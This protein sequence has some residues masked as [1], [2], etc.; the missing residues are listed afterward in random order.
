LDAKVK[1]NTS[2]GLQ[3]TTLLKPSDTGQTVWKW[4]KAGTEPNLT[5]MGGL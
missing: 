5:G 3:K 1:L 4:N 2:K